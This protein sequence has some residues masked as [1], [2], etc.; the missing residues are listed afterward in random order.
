MFV[1]FTNMSPNYVDYTEPS[2]DISYH[3]HI[4]QT[5][6]THV[7]GVTPHH[8]PLNT[9]RCLMKIYTDFFELDFSASTLEFRKVSDGTI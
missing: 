6:K 4:V 3:E 9:Y 1:E 2:M 5:F 8:I 7:L